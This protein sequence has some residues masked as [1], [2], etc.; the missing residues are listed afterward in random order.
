[1]HSR[2]QYN[3]CLIQAGGKKGVF[4]NKDD[5]VTEGGAPETHGPWSAHS[6]THIS[7]KRVA[8]L[9]QL[10]LEPEQR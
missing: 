1:M 2:E 10:A 4:E 9:R 6:M 8:Y 3:I 7:M 5:R